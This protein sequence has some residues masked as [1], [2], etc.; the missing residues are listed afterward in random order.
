MNDMS[1]SFTFKKIQTVYNTVQQS[2]AVGSDLLIMKN[3]RT[4]KALISLCSNENTY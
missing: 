1:C 4:S 3:L 2:E